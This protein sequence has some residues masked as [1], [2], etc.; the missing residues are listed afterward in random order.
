[1]FRRFSNLLLTVALASWL[2]VHWSLLQSIAWVGMVIKYSQ[3]AT[4]TEALSK[5]FDGEHPC[6]LCKVITAGKKAEKKAAV[7]RP[8]QKLEFLAQCSTFAFFS[9]SEFELLP[10]PVN[11]VRSLA[12][13]PP[14]PPPK[15]QSVSV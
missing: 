2:G 7:L 14:T 4:M 15:A 5:T 11:S 1:V 12:Y 6:A 13:A 10:T 3:G 8:V 9:P